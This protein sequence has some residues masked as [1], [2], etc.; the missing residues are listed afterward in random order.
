[1]RGD[2]EPH[3]AR[4]TVLFVGLHHK[5]L[6]ITIRELVRRGYRVRVLASLGKPRLLTEEDGVDRS[7]IMRS[8]EPP[9]FIPKETRRILKNI[10]DDCRLVVTP[11]GRTRTKHVLLAAGLRQV[12]AVLNFETDCRWEVD[13]ASRSQSI[14]VAAVRLFRAVQW[15]IH[16]SPSYTT[17]RGPGEDVRRWDLVFVP[18]AVEPTLAEPPQLPSSPLR[19]LSVTQCAPGKNNSGLISVAQRCREE[20]IDFTVVF[21][22]DR[23]CK[24][25]RGAVIDAFRADVEASGVER[26]RVLPRMPDITHLYRTHHVVVRNSVHEGANYTLIEGASEGCIPV[27]SPESGGAYG[28]LEDG[29]S[30]YVVPGADDAGYARVLVGLLEDPAGRER[31]RAAALRFAR[32]HCGPEVLAD[33]LEQHMSDA[34]RRGVRRIAI[35]DSAA[36]TG[37]DGRI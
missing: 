12:P 19:V 18:H 5:N 3:G 4:G 17:S 8:A 34:D 33:F 1:M 28:Y 32:S 20:D 11:A 37:R 10:D 6:R 14:R 35:E 36:R 24:G 29:R 2:P 31:M 9:R 22:C 26:V 25:C 13:H 15:S 23:D 27:G 7:P 30:G 16:R 21:S